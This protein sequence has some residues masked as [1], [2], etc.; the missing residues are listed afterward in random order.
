MS[1]EGHLAI[2]LCQIKHVAHQEEEEEITVC[3]KQG[4][5]Y[6][7]TVRV[8][9]IIY[10]WIGCQQS[11]LHVFFLLNV[12]VKFLSSVNKY[13]RLFTGKITLLASPLLPVS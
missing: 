8:A 5:V 6:L 11:I 9:Q 13:I 7:L 2:N 3:L 4:L 10:L 12:I 1:L